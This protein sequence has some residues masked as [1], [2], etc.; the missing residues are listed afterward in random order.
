M[1]RAGWLCRGD[2]YLGNY[3]DPGITLSRYRSEFQPTELAG[4]SC[5]RKVDFHGV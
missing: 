2:F 4:M 3:Y 1:S 5:D